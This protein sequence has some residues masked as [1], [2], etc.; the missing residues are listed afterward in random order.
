MFISVDQSLILDNAVK[1]F[2]VAFR[3]F[4]VDILV[5]NYPTE[6]S[7][8]QDL[9]SI[10]TG[11]GV[12]YA[13]KL[14]AKIT[15]LKTNI[16]SVYK[17]IL[18][19]NN[20][21]ATKTYNNN[22]PYV[23]ELIDFL[24]I[25]F[26]KHFSDKHLTDNFTSVEDFHF[27]ASLYHKIRNDLSHPASHP[28][29]ESDANKVIYFIKNLMAILDEKYFWYNNKNNIEG[30]INDYYN[31]K[32]KTTLKITNLDNVRFLHKKVLCR[33]TE[34][35]KLSNA[36]LGTDSRRRLAGSVSLYGYGGVGKT[37][38]TIDFLYRIMREK[39]DGKHNNIDYLLFFSSKEEYLTHQ[40][41]T[42]NLYINKV[43]PEFQSLDEL[44]SKICSTL[45]M[46]NIDEIDK[47][48]NGGIIVIDNIE[49]IS[50]EEKEKIFKFIN[51]LPSEV[52]FIITSRNEEQG[53]ERIHLQE[54]NDKEL[55]ERF[56]QEYLL[57][58]DIFLDLNEHDYEKLLSA[59]KGNV[60]ILIQLLNILSQKTSTLDT[61]VQSLKNLKA[62]NA[63][64]ISD[65]MYK[66]TFTESMET[67]R[68]KGVPPEKIIQIISLY[69]EPIDLYS[70]SRLTKIDVSTAE[71]VCNYFA[72]QLIL[73]KT[74]EY[75][76]LNEFASRFVFIKMLPDRIELNK[77]ED[78]I[79]NHKERM[80]KSLELLDEKIQSNEKIQQIMNDWQPQNYI[81][82]IVIAELF[83]TFQQAKK[84]VI[85][86]DK[87]GY[88]KVVNDMEE[89]T[90]ISDHPYIAFQAAR[91]LKLGYEKFYKDDSI[92]LKKIETS[93]ENAIESIQ[94][95]HRY[96]MENNSYPSILMIFG[97]FLNE[98]NNNFSKAI[99]YL[100][101]A[102]EIF[103]TNN[104]I[105]NWFITT[106]YLLK[107]YNNQY[108]I[109]NDRAYKHRYQ[110]LIKSACEKRK[111]YTDI[112][113]NKP[114][115]KI[116]IAQSC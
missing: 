12:I 26:N 98:D 96:L 93:Y 47:K 52:Q 97:I 82:K 85:N 40:N 62:K 43:K 101:K 114:L 94:F 8:L 58:E 16:P 41:T 18:N 69:D 50:S 9:N 110:K 63:E 100:E 21:Y 111:K 61:L 79:K 1:S 81:D 77:L 48:Y 57:E 23:S 17:V 103:N 19:C 34:L 3:S 59:S 10:N 33:D 44:I 20:S 13:G 78:A 87:Q 107:A 105:T 108:N 86:N 66:N 29:N 115:E 51:S 75:F 15:N 83:N 42:G 64:V 5:N 95:D 102:L 112:R 30:I 65:F 91:V 28:V 70:L 27:S 53:D 11:N 24:L 80:Q 72:Q 38:L 92:L 49:N 67:I 45:A 4:I 32:N 104:A 31:I 55:G 73:N 88:E 22:V 6:N 71:E 106:N 56:I 99:R 84:Y 39:K 25:F 36:L 37:A 68:K 113:I 109:T 116:L 76:A 7:I 35:E 89:Q 2:E 60:L 90:L 54:F 46:E 14:N 74:G